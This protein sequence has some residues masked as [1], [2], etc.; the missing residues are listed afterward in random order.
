MVTLYQR[1]LLEKSGLCSLIGILSTKLLATSRPGVE[2]DKKPQ[3]TK[4]SP[5]L[6]Q[7]VGYTGSRISA[8]RD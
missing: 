5:R 8:Q 2:A 7:D 6:R 4:R 1:M 3:I